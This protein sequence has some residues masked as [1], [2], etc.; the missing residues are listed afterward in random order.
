M[1]RPD[2][3]WGARTY[4]LISMVFVQVTNIAKPLDFLSGL[5]EGD[6]TAL[7]MAYSLMP[8]F[9][10]MKAYLYFWYLAQNTDPLDAITL[11]QMP[12]LLASDILL[13]TF[14]AGCYW[15]MFQLF[16]VTSSN[17]AYPLAV[18]T[19]INL[20]VIV[21]TAISLKVNQ[22][23]GS[24]LTVGH[25][26]IA[27]DLVTMRGSMQHSIDSHAISVLAIGMAVT[28]IAFRYRHAM[29]ENWQIKRLLVWPLMLVIAMVLG[30]GAVKALSGV[31]TYGIKKNPVVNFVRYY[32]AVPEPREL[33]S[34]ADSLDHA[35]LDGLNL[36]GPESTQ[37][38]VDKQLGNLTGLAANHNVI[39][40]VLESSAE[41][42]IDAETTPNL[43]RMKQNSLVFD[44]F[45]TTAVNSF[46]AN[47]SI[48]FS[49]YMLDVERFGHPST[50]YRA[51][52]PNRGLMQS[53]LDSG[54]D[55]GVFSSG[56]LDYTDI[57][58]LWRGMG[59][60]ALYGAKDILQNI[61]GT[62]WFWGAHETQTITVMEK[63]LAKKRDKPFAAAYIT[64]YPHHPYHTPDKIKPFGTET[65]RARFRNS[66]HY[67]DRTVGTLL[68]HLKRHNLLDN[69]IIAVVGDHG[70]T[71]VG[72]RAGHG[73]Q[74]DLGE[75]QVPFFVHN[76]TLFGKPIHRSITANLND[77]APT[78][79]GLL[80]VNIPKEWLGRNLAQG[81]TQQRRLFVQRNANNEQSAIIE[82]DLVHVYD[83]RALKTSFF[84]LEEKRMSELPANDAGEALTGQ[85]SNLDDMFED[86]VLMRHLKRACSASGDGHEFC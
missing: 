58:Y 22:L 40:I 47:Y 41:S 68:S 53:V 74:M 17:R 30:V 63:W 83:K 79:A 13:C 76:R 8:F 19:S 65:W 23:Y 6:R 84:R 86:W 54:F 35:A 82:G 59:V 4:G 21:F 69:T 56:L 11:L 34:I 45:F 29:S 32:E 9:A 70:Q 28:I 43:H 26:R 12:L 66:L 14:L 25:I 48:F 18:M 62:G 3:S 31:Y 15:C 52:M 5:L 57:G 39:L 81:N 24:P 73:I 67:V 72:S 55:T 78:L 77:L 51:P 16:S 85:L 64:A 33:R 20:F 75:M 61:D 44:N 10:A 50:I 36:F 7:I 38:S 49:D 71:I 60:N 80:G 46:R 1:R 2:W 27:D 37:S 42:F